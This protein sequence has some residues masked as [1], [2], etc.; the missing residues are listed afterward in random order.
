MEKIRDKGRVKRDKSINRV[1]YFGTNLARGFVLLRWKLANGRHGRSTA[2]LAC[3]CLSF[4]S[5]WDENRNSR[6]GP[7]YY[8]AKSIAA[9]PCTHRGAHTASLRSILG[10]HWAD[11]LAGRDCQI[12][13]FRLAD[14]MSHTAQQ[15]SCCM[16]LECSFSVS[17]QYSRLLILLLIVHWEPLVEPTLVAHHGQC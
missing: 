14:H 16:G 1:N 5:V 17:A 12:V 9:K 7:Q 2:C 11:Q 3:V 13:C 6:K 10:S 15:R 4:I 8:I